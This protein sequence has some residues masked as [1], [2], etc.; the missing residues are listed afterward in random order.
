MARPRIPQSRKKAVRLPTIFRNTP[1]EEQQLKLVP[2]THL[3]ALAD[4]KG[5]TNAYAT[6]VFRT[7][8]GGML[9]VLTEEQC[10]KA[11]AAEFDEAIRALL[12]MGER[13]E[14]GLPL[15]ATETEHALIGRALVLADDLQDVCTR[16]QQAEAYRWVEPLVG[17]LSFTVR[18][19][20]VVLS[21][22]P[23]AQRP[24]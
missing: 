4:G 8:V 11:L 18:Q 15:I 10:E 21:H 17:G 12:A 24:N 13:H 20:R 5:T 9:T 7:L 1:A 3:A 19:L 6:V 16:K 2:H 23:S 14:G 22:R